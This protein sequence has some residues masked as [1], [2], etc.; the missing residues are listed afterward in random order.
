MTKK[1]KTSGKNEH[2]LKVSEGSRVSTFGGN[3]SVSTD[4]WRLFQS[5]SDTSEELSTE[6]PLDRAPSELYASVCTAS[7]INL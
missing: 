3:G 4:E 7:Q 1:N 6:F 5:S 2:C